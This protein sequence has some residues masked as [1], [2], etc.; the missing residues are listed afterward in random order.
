MISLISFGLRIVHLIL[1]NIIRVTKI[2]NLIGVIIKNK[3]LFIYL[4]YRQALFG[5][6]ARHKRIRNKHHC[7]YRILQE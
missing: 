1:E 7:N 2:I 3:D 5:R 6:S 4:I